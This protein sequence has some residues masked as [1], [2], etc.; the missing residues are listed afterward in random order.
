MAQILGF[1]I[2][3]YN[4]LQN[5]ELGKL[6]N[7]NQQALTPLTVVIGKNGVGKSSL[8][9]AFG[10]ISDC[11]KVGVEDACDIRGGFGK[12]FSKGQNSSDSMEFEIY[13]KE[14]ASNR[15]ITY[16]F[17]ISLDEYGRPFVKK[18]RRRG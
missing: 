7:N 6:W 9:D 2:H 11:L 13:Y 12:I 8:F 16:E 15:P 10:F 14:G 17:S 5:V 1:R 3:N 4:A 18:E